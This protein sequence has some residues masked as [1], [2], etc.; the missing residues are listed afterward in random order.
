MAFLRN[1]FRDDPEALERLRTAEENP[2][3]LNGINMNNFTAINIDEITR[4]TCE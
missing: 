3:L 4:L 1:Y 2:E